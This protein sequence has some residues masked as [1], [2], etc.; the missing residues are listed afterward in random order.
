MMEAERQRNW[1]PRD[2]PG[3]PSLDP[4]VQRKISNPKDC[5]HCSVNFDANSRP[6]TDRDRV[7][8]FNKSEQEQR[9]RKGDSSHATGNPESKV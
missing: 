9:L 6:L 2:V 8:A 1:I 4:H 5:E 3:F 7:S